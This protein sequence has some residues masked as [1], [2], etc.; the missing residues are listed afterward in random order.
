M[1]RRSYLGVVACGVVA[2]CLGDGETVEGDRETGDDARGGDEVR[3]PDA[4]FDQ[5]WRAQLDA[6]PPNMSVDVALGVDALFVGHSG[7][8]TALDLRD[9]EQRWRREEWG[10]YADVYAD[11]RGVLALTYDGTLIEL[12]PDTGD[13]DWRTS[14]EGSEENIFWRAGATAQ[15]VLVSTDAETT[16]YNRENGDAVRKF[17]VPQGDVVTAADVAVLVLAFE[18][19]GVDPE[20][21][22]E[23]WQTET[24]ISRDGT[25]GNGVL[26]AVETGDLEEGTVAALDVEDGDPLW[27]V[28]IDHPGTGFVDVAITDGVATLIT[29]EDGEWYTLSAFDV[30][31]GSE[32]WTADLG[33][34]RS[35]F[36]PPAVDD[37]VVITETEDDIRAFDAATGETLATTDRPFSIRAALAGEGLFFEWASDEVVAYDLFL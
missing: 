26:V 20:T 19:I 4:G 16:L 15:S 7:G 28:D 12:D 1:K 27:E 31:D 35:P 36:R 29:G 9:G 14:V 22:T 30:E 37:G 33:R 8:L 13:E 11:H 10:E 6:D 17:D 25:I 3:D 23:R 32:L 18:A 5:R 34:F 2:G 24:R 21:G